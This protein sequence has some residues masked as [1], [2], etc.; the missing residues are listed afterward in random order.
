MDAIRKNYRKRHICQICDQSLLSNTALEIHKK[1]SHSKDPKQENVSEILQK[2]IKRH[3]NNVF[4]PPI[5]P[6]Q[7]KI[8]RNKY[9]DWELRIR[10]DIDKIGVKTCIKDLRLGYNRNIMF[11]DA[12]K[13]SEAV[14]QNLSDLSKSYTIYRAVFFINL[15]FWKTLKHCLS[16]LHRIW[17]FRF[18]L[19]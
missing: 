5:D 6:I 18:V 2:E 13:L 3:I 8:T 4:I 10:Q 14:C 16:N 19:D 7:Q 17:C 11:I 9:Q 15:F 12:L 1:L